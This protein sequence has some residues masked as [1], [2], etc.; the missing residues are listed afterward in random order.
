MH[1]HAPVSSFQQ[2]LAHHLKLILVMPRHGITDLQRKRKLNIQLSLQSLAPHMPSEYQAKLLLCQGERAR[3]SE[4][5]RFNSSTSWKS[6][7][8]ASRLKPLWPLQGSQPQAQKMFSHEQS[9]VMPFCQECHRRNV[10]TAHH[11]HLQV[12]KMGSEPHIPGWGT[13]RSQPEVAVVA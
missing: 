10:P 8:A 2:T 6:V 1:T 11:T 12:W 7:R 4:L 5:K 3:C 9:Q 13:P